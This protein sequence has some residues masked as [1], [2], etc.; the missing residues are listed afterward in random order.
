M[1]ERVDYDRVARGYD[2]RYVEHEYDGILRAL[3]R[4]TGPD[5]AVLEVGCGTGQW[6]AHLRT[7][8]CRAVGV[9]PSLEMLR[10]AADKNPD[11][12]LVRGRAE[13]LPFGADRFDRVVVVNALHHFEQPTAFA[14]EALRVLRP[15]GRVMVLG[16]AP[17]HGSEDWFIYRY[18]PRTLELDRARYPSPGQIQT[19]LGAAGFEACSAGPGHAIRYRKSAREVL[20]TGALTPDSTSQLS[21]LDDDEFE[22]GVARIRSAAQRDPALAL[23]ADLRLPATYGTKPD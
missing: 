20:D 14:A 21:L 6:I 13:Q 9:E 16:L 1:P 8:G 4:L 5:Q 17:D 22:A 12:H 18:F 10:R 3:D 11:A 15:G 23:G 7:L 2:R 19:W